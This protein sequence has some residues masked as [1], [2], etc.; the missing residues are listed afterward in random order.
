MIN[1]TQT[2][3]SKAYYWAMKTKLHERCSR[4]SLSLDQTQPSPSHRLEKEKEEKREEEEKNLYSRWPAWWSQTHE[5]LI[6]EL[7][8]MQNQ[9]NSSPTSS[10]HTHTPT[11][12][13]YDRS[14]KIFLLSHT[15]WLTIDRFVAQ[16][17]TTCRSH[18]DDQPLSSPWRK[19]KRKRRRRRDEFI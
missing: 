1:N 10:S 2:L 3:T 16:W 11:S 7:R 17:L 6:C 4:N 19:K 14:M 15:Q 18:R 9:Q 12:W 5:T 13:T 8:T